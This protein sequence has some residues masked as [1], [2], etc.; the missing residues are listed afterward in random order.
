M[1]SR[2]DPSRNSTDPVS[3]PEAV[4]GV[5]VSVTMRP[6]TSAAR[7]VLVAILA[8]VTVRVGEVDPV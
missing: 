3:V 2:V 4:V 1:P 6:A 5:A 7:A 8:T